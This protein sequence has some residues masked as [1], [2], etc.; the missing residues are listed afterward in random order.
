MG[1]KNQSM[2]VPAEGERWACRSCGEPMQRWKHADA[3]VPPTN[4]GYF[5]Y[6]FEC[7]NKHCRTQQVM[8]PGAFV[9]PGGEAPSGEDGP[10]SDGCE[11][12]LCAEDIQRLAY[13]RMI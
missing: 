13:F 3:W 4:K 12:A 10:R 2:R 9:K 5:T 11:E 1:K 6:W 7:L 8:P